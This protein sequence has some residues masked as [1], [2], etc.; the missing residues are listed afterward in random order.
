[1][2]KTTDREEISIIFRNYSGKYLTSTDEKD[3]FI[4]TTH[5][6]SFSL[7]SLR[8]SKE[9]EEKDRREEE[10]NDEYMT[11]FQNKEKEKSNQY[12]RTD[13]LDLIRGEEDT[14]SSL[15]S[16]PSSLFERQTVHSFDNYEGLCHQETI[17]PHSISPERTIIGKEE[18][19]NEELIYTQKEEKE[20]ERERKAKEEEA[21]LSRSNLTK[22]KSYPTYLFEFLFSQ[23]APNITP[24]PLKNTT[25]LNFTF[26]QPTL[27]PSAFFRE[28]C[29]L[30]R[31][32]RE[33]EVEEKEE[34]EKG[35]KEKDEKV[36]EEEQVKED[37]ERMQNGGE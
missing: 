7:R 21:L 37:E 2:L 11:F 26:S 6:S 28:E 23:E 19:T 8:C 18:M 5:S 16:S 9:E 4:N 1:M 27:L 25:H 33:K 32:G 30:S 20:E 17:F 10:S 34:K 3:F 24:P 13:L 35:E 15:P 29:M 31:G 22:M 12:I 36:K 14:I